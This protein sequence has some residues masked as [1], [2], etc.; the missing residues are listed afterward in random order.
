MLKN[1]NCEPFTL[2]SQDIV[3][4]DKSGLVTPNELDAAKCGRLVVDTDGANDLLVGPDTSENAKKLQQT[5]GVTKQ[6][7][8]VLLIIYPSSTYIRSSIT[9][10]NTSGTHT[11]VNVSLLYGK[12]VI[13]DAD[14]QIL[15]SSYSDTSVGMPEGC[16]RPAIVMVTNISDISG[17]ERIRFNILQQG[18]FNS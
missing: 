8:K 17:Y 15:F 1:K 18:G 16:G 7:D 14:I 2:D 6:D 10:A 3:I 12:N 5:L 13:I 9:L 11:W 4:H